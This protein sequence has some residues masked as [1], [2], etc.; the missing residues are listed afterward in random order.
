M[1]LFF[2]RTFP[3]RDNRDNLIAYGAARKPKAAIPGG[4]VKQ[5]TS[6]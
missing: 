5:S 2:V 1:S 6:F 3:G 4:I